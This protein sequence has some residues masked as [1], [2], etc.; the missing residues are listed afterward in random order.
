MIILIIVRLISIC[1]S[2]AIRAAI[3]G[4]ATLKVVAVPANNA[5]TASKSIILPAIP[6]VCFPN[7]GL[8]ASE[9]FF[10]SQLRTWSINPNAAAKSK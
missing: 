10:F 8:Q 2:S 6:S 5:N 4:V 7:S 3:S 1:K 9:Y